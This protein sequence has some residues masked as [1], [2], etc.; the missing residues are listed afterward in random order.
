MKRKEVEDVIGGKDAWENVDRAD[1]ESLCAVLVLVSW[2][3]EG[4]GTGAICKKEAEGGTE[5]F[6]EKEVSLGRQLF[7]DP[8]ASSIPSPIPE[9]PGPM[10][11]NFLS[12]LPYHPQHP[13]SPHTKEAT[14][15]FFLHST[16]SP[17]RL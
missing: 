7:G 17:R 5:S 10:P 4:G 16:M 12:I 8:E 1:G 9:T 14:N 3:A 15:T 13:L 2:G 11:A 6:L